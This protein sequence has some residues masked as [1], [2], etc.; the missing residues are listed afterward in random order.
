MDAVM[1]IAGMSD[2]GAR[3]KEQGTRE[4]GEMAAM[5]LRQSGLMGDLFND[6]PN[7]NHNDNL[8]DNADDDGGEPEMAGRL[9]DVKRLLRGDLQEEVDKVAMYRSERAMASERAKEEALKGSSQEV[10]AKYA[11]EAAEKE[12]KV[13]RIYRMVDENLAMVYISARLWKEDVV[14][15]EKREDVLKETEYYYR[16][17][18]AK[19]KTFEG[20][21][22]AK[23]AGEGA[24]MVSQHREQGE[25]QGA[26]SEGQDAGVEGQ[27]AMGKG[28]EELLQG[29]SDKERKKRI[30][31]AR[32]YFMRKARPSEGRLKKMREKIDEVKMLGGNVEDLELV[33]RK[34]EEDLRVKG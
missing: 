12:E 7:L 1:Q 8:N 29:I 34:E 9:Q 22:L 26:K 20:R 25:G 33:F 27:G 23:L 13:Q 17:V 32:D 10:V 30:K 28:Q 31:Y 14:A 15:G 11:Q 19:D 16:K 2:E 24:A 4:R 21:Y 18:V 3:G 6:N 5:V